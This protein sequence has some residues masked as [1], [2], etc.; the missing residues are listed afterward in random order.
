MVARRGK[1]TWKVPKEE[2]HVLRP[3]PYR[4]EMKLPDSEVETYMTTLLLGS[5][6]VLSEPL[7]VEKRYSGKEYQ[8]HEHQYLVHDIYAWPGS[9]CFRIGTLALYSGQVRVT[10]S[11]PDGSVMRPT[12]HTFIIDGAKYMTLNLRNFRPAA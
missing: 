2:A 12:R 1:L 6:W 7:I 5:L 3:Q 8:Q 10:E 11:A 9:T 4:S